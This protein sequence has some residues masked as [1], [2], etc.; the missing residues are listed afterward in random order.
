MFGS[1]VLVYPSAH[2]GGALVLRYH[3]SEWTFDFAA[4]LARCPEPSVAYIAF[5]GDVEHEVLPV[6]SGY[7]VTATYNLCF[8][9]EWYVDPYHR[10]PRSSSN[11]NISVFRRELE[12]CLADRSFLPIGGN[13]GFRLRHE[14]PVTVRENP[15]LETAHLKGTDFDV[16]HACKTLG[17][18]VSVYTLYN[19][20]IICPYVVDLLDARI[21]DDVE[22]FLQDAWGGIRVNTESQETWL[23]YRD[24][25]SDSEEDAGFYWVTQ[26]GQTNTVGSDYE[27]RGNEVD[28]GYIYGFLCL[29]VRIPPWEERQRKREESRRHPVTSEQGEDGSEGGTST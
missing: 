7:R 1:L 21:E 27:A 18:R 22:W 8:D 3:R 29:V 11:R 15:I 16:L 25:D 10:L 5:Y 17:L 23:K 26:R 19:D 20:T 12:S 24:Y 4:D 14:Y 28:I 6:T 2:E 13:L 9:A